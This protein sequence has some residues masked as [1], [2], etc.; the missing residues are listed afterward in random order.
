MRAVAEKHGLPWSSR[1]GF[2]PL[3]QKVPEFVAAERIWQDGVAQRNAEMKQYQ[4]LRD[5]YEKEAHCLCVSIFEDYEYGDDV[6][7]CRRHLMELV[8]RLEVKP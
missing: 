4:D 6:W 2:H 7:L 5:L 3:L 1:S 8:E